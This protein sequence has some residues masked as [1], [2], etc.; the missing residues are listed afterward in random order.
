[1]SIFSSFINKD[2]ERFM[3]YHA[4]TMFPFG[5]LIRSGAKTYDEPYG[6]FE[7]RAMQ[8]FFGIPLDKVRSRI[9]RANVLKARQE[10]INNE[11]SEMEN[12]V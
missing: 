7:G 2:W 3:D 4:Y 1:M 9:D 8:Q 10:M 5:R 11:M 12:I 6:T